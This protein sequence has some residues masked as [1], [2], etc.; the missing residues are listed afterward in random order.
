MYMCIS[1]YTYTYAYEYGRPDALAWAAWQRSEEGWVYP[2]NLGQ[3]SWLLAVRWVGRGIK[4]KRSYAYRWVVRKA[5]VVKRRGI[6][7]QDCA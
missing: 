5:R 4:T 1:P 6:L 3:R 2:Q 7:L